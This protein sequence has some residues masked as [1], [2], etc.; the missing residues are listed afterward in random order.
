[1]FDVGMKRAG[2]G[3]TLVCVLALV[4]A[5]AAQAAVGPSDFEMRA[6]VGA[7]ASSA[8]AYTSHVLR[9]PKH[10]DLVGMRWH[11]RLRPTISLRARKA[12]GHWTKWTRVPADS[13]D[14]PDVGSRERSA[15]GF[16]APVWTGDADSVDALVAQGGAVPAT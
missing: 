6:P 4:L 1:V 8:G 15:G 13:D 10:F 9:A 16:S 5:G 11:G 2:S 14:S 12:D 7:S 3:F